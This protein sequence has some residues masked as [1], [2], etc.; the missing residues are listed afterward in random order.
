MTKERQ[1]HRIYKPDVK[2]VE[3]P[4]VGHVEQLVGFGST[5]ELHIFTHRCDDSRARLDASVER[6]SLLDDQLAGTFRLTV[7]V[8]SLAGV[9]SGVG[10]VD[11][12][13]EEV[14]AGED[15]ILAAGSQLVAVLAPI[16]K[17]I[18][19]DLLFD[20]NKNYQFVKIVD[21]LSGLKTSMLSITSL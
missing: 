1:F 9:G 10:N 3:P 2:S 12:T 19:L 15:G 17:L 7:L 21:S 5:P 4:A 20:K 18:Q 14:A 6:R 16:R 11:A 8:G 13:D